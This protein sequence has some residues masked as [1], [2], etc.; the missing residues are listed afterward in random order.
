MIRWGPNLIGKMAVCCSYVQAMSF[1]SWMEL[2]SAAGLRRAI[3]VL[4]NNI[5]SS[6][7]GAKRSNDGSC[8]TV[9]SKAA[10]ECWSNVQSW[11]MW[12]GQIK[13]VYLLLICISNGS[14]AL[15]S[16][17]FSF[18]SA[19]F[20]LLFC[21]CVCLPTSHIACLLRWLSGSLEKSVQSRFWCA[22]AFFI[23]LVPISESQSECKQGCVTV[24]A[25]LDLMEVVLIIHMNHMM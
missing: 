12:K 17:L 6:Y 4:R 24:V 16:M 9:C 11:S 7:D 14:C 13:Y 2:V 22:F 25:N 10:Q 15:T 18:N 20:N 5:S 8:R 3:K 23:K 19:I 1:W 21:M